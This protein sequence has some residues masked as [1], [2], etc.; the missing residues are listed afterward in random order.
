ML[1]VDVKWEESNQIKE[2]SW[3]SD[4]NWPEKVGHS[5]RTRVLEMWDN[6]RESGTILYV[7]WPTSLPRYA[8]THR[9]PISFLG[10]LGGPLSVAISGRENRD[11]VKTFEICVQ[12]GATSLILGYQ[13][14]LQP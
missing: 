10:V 12:G 3:R 7:T 8:Q 5:P 1:K 13:L 14:V 6:T 11:K 2:Q 9:L 4:K